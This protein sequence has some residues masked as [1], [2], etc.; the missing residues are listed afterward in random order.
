M[1]QTPDTPPMEITLEQALDRLATHRA[2]EK[3]Q[4]IAAK[5]LFVGRFFKYRNRFSEEESWWL[6]A[7]GTSVNEHGHLA[8]LRF[9]QR[10]NG[11]L[12]VEHAQFGD[13][14]GGW[15]EIDA[16]EFWSA[17]REFVTT[18]HSAMAIPND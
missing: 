11:S 18:V 3:A 17:A 1:T 16:G 13:L 10:S 14:T 12:E 2:T 5:Q 7:M 4:Q 9:Q 8:T 6:Y 15:Q